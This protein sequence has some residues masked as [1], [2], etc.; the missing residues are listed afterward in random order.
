MRLAG[1]VDGPPD[2]SARKGFSPGPKRDS[3]GDDK[4]REV[5]K[6]HRKKQGN[7]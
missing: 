3:G 4:L 2:L 5:A 6:E 7:H 1:V